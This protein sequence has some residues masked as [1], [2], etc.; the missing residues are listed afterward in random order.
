LITFAFDH[1]EKQAMH[2]L[3]TQEMLDRGFL[4]SKSVYASYA[5]TKEH[6]S[7]YLEN[8][9]K[10]FAII[11]KAD[12]SKNVRKFLRGPVAESGFKRLA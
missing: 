3:F 8:V 12:E 2:T 1:E 7:K 4:A 11:K 6:V 10:A 5:H 9:D